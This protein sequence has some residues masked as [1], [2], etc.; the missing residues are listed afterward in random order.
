MGRQY[1]PSPPA[2]PQTAS[3]RVFVVMGNDYPHSVYGDQEAA[4]TY[5]AERMAAQKVGKPTWETPQIHYR[6]YPFDVIRA[7]SIAP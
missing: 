1:R 5:C 4:D 3:E 6:V 7:A 2:A